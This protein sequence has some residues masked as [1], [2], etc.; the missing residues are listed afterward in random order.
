MREEW[1]TPSFYAMDIEY[2]LAFGFTY[3]IFAI[4]YTYAGKYASRI[5][6]SGLKILRYAGVYPMSI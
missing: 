3:A 4:A 2:S 6:I 1:N 5:C